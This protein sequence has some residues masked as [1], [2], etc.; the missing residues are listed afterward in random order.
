MKYPIQEIVDRLSILELKRERLPENEDILKEIAI[1]EPEVVGYREWVD[2][3][4]IAN[5]NIWDLEFDIRRGK[6]KEL[7]LEE[8]GRR[9]LQIRDYNKKRIEIKNEL[10]LMLGN[11]KEIKV[12]HASS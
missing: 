8:V 10:A 5:G 1:L 6:E 4:K 3:L 9:A 7:G 12:D 2:K 11:P